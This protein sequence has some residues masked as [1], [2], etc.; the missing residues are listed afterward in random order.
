MDGVTPTKIDIRFA[1]QEVVFR[2][3]N[4]SLHKDYSFWK[5]SKEQAECFQE[6]LRHFEQLNWSQFGNL[7]RETG[8]TKEKPG[9]DSFNM[10]HE[11]NTNL[12]KIA[13]QYYFHFRIKQSS[14]FRVFG[15]QWKQFFFITHID[16][17]GQIHDHGS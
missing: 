2:I 15:Y 4:C 16:R 1:Q 14:L 12:E 9:S 3:S 6:R 13:E 8:I 17:E 7:P 11:Q 5:L 10:I